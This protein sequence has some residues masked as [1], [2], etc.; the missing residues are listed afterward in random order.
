MV[1]AQEWLDEN[2]PKEKRNEIT[3]LDIHNQGLGG[4]LDLRDFV[5]IEYLDCSK[6]QLTSMDLSNCK[7]LQSISCYDNQLSSIDFL[8]ELPNP[9]NINYLS[10]TVFDSSLPLS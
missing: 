4:H 5:N 1:N 6:N 8:K 7:N 3:N 9:T 10:I 2:Y